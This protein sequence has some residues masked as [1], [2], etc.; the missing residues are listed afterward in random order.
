MIDPT[1]RG[2]IV[3][4][5]APGYAPVMSRPDIVV[6]AEA[7]GADSIGW[8]EA[9]S[10]AGQV[11]H[12]RP[13]Y[14]V[15]VGRSSVNTRLVRSPMGDAGDTPISVREGHR[16]VSA[17]R[18]RITAPGLPRKF[19]PERWLTVATYESPAGLVTHIN[20]HPSPR[21][22]VPFQWRKVMAAALKAARSA[23]AAGNH[24]VLTGDLQTKRGVRALLAGAGMESWNAHV[25]W[26]G[27]SRSL[28]LVS[29][30]Q[31]DVEGL[32]HPWLLGT[33]VAR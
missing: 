20:V 31:V 28:R 2:T 14:Q 13:G 26:L 19:A 7:T 11:L 15:R 27:W 21:F 1:P 10:I 22:C 29:A 24:V 33:F 16:I 23:R 17:R 3:V 4:L 9:Y 5:H 32:D 25:D 8:S 6:R 18:T 30:K 12:N